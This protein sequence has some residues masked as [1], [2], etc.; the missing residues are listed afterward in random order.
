MWYNKHGWTGSTVY[1]HLQPGHV[2]SSLSILRALS[3]SQLQLLLHYTSPY[4]L[5]L[6]GKLML[7]H[8][9][10]RHAN[11][12]ALNGLRPNLLLTLLMRSEEAS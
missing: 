5:P 6:R 3:T 10:V 9:A 2:M 8:W 12:N 4:A 7:Q 11:E 1:S